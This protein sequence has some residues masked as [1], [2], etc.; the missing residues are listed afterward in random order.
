MSGFYR[1]R[2]APIIKSIPEGI[3][4]LEFKWRCPDSP[5]ILWS[6]TLLGISYHQC[7]VCYDFYYLSDCCVYELAGFLVNVL[8]KPLCLSSVW[9]V[10]VFWNE[11]VFQSVQQRGSVWELHTVQCTVII[12]NNSKYILCLKFVVFVIPTFKS[13]GTWWNDKLILWRDNMFTIFIDG[14]PLLMLLLLTLV[15]HA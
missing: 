4:W 10:A 6:H 8:Q 5:D 12:L 15:G 14:Q 13:F 7:L 1:Q 2:S 11:D 3:L 9:W